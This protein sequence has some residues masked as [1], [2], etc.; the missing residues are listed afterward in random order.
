VYV[1]EIRYIHV[2]K[3]KKNLEPWAALLESRVP[4]VHVIC[5]FIDSSTRRDIATET[6]V[7]TET[8]LAEIRCRHVENC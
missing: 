1:N 6:P 8:A 7:R 4:V 2:E 5:V 3:N